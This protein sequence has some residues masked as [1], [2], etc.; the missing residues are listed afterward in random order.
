MNIYEYNNSIYVCGSNHEFQGVS[1]EEFLENRGY[2]IS[3]LKFIE[4]D[5]TVA[6]Y[7][8][9]EMAAIFHVINSHGC[10]GKSD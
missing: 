1:L 7:Y 8:K 10:S 9:E 2:D 3:N 6:D 5:K 4:Y